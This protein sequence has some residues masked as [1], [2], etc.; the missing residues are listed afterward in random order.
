MSS[1]LLDPVRP[2]YDCLARIAPTIPTLVFLD[3]QFQSNPLLPFFLVALLKKT[4]WHKVVRSSTVHCLDSWS[5]FP[6]WWYSNTSWE[7]RLNITQRSTCWP[8]IDWKDNSGV[9][10][11]GKKPAQVSQFGVQALF[12]F[13]YCENWFGKKNTEN[14]INAQWVSSYRNIMRDFPVTDVICAVA[15]LLFWILHP[16]TK[17]KTLTELCQMFVKKNK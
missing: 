11:T 16:E 6:P 17:E 14:R 8:I 9:G 15:A 4:Q 1:K 10:Q 2:R 13:H 7:C 3:S 5:W 12:F